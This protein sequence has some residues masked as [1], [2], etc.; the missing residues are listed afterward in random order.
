[1]TAQIQ[2][3]FLLNTLANVQELVESGSPRA[4]P[5]FRSL[6]AYLRAAVPQL[7]QD[8]GTLGDEERLVTAYLEL[9]QMRMPDRLAFSVD[10]E[11]AL[12]SLAFRRWRC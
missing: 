11:P 7:Q 5:V 10:V 3:H 2:P 4:V 1:M 9:M 12:R 8:V 6:I